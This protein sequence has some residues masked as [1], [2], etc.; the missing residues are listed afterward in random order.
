MANFRFASN[1]GVQLD[2]S[3]MIH[4][5]IF[6]MNKDNIQSRLSKIPD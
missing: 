3:E 4:D 5:K 6:K 2:T 1:F